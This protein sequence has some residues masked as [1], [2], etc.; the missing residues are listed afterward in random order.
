MEFNIISIEPMFE[1]FMAQLAPLFEGTA[2]DTT[3]EN[4]QA[5]CR[6]VLLMALST[7]VAASC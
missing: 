6:G 1:G 4:L 7:S 2:R 3:E 5:R